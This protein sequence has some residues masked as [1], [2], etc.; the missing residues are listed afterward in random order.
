[1]KIL[2]EPHI[3]QTRKNMIYDIIRAKRTKDSKPI[4]L[5][6]KL[7]EKKKLIAE[8]QVLATASEKD[9][10]LA[11]ILLN[12]F[13]MLQQDICMYLNKSKNIKSFAKY[14]F[15]SA[16]KLLEESEQITKNEKKRRKE[17][18][19]TYVRVK[20]KKFAG[21]IEIDDYKNGELTRKVLKIGNTIT[22]TAFDLNRNASIFSFDNEGNLFSYLEG[23]TTSKH[24]F[25][26]KEKFT[27]SDGELSLIDIDYKQ[28]SDNSEESKNH[29][30]IKN[31]KPVEVYKSYNKLVNQD[32]EV[33]ADEF[34]LFSSKEFPYRYYKK[35]SITPDKEK[36][37]EL[38]FKYETTD[39]FTH[40]KECIKHEKV[41]NQQD[42]TFIS[43]YKKRKLKAIYIQDM[44]TRHLRYFTFDLE[45]KPINYYEETLES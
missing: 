41:E 37:S 42:K 13:K 35:Y 3:N 21:G 32:I 18:N 22:V 7:A 19:N 45:G 31:N 15:T 10:K 2:A 14:E 40:L 27:Y 23:V 12:D 16:K 24:I 28:Y 34:F 26:A 25:N 36:S 43:R 11:Y 8:A 1:M 39:F 38:E 44:Q 9:G 6:P 33:S 20:K 4:S 17:N 29:F 5:F 30:V